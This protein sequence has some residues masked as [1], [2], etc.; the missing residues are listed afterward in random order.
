[1]SGIIQTTN[2]M[3][4]QNSPDNYIRMRVSATYVRKGSL[5]T[6]A[7][8]GYIRMR[9]GA[10]YICSRVSHTYATGSYILSVRLSHTEAATLPIRRRRPPTNAGSLAT[11]IATI[12]YKH[13]K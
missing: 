1:M 12:I 7:G 10:T 3:S 4:M 8:G 9:K 6:Y 2:K 11:E 13:F 5:H